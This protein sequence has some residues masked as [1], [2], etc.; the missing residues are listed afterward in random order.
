VK[1]RNIIA[2]TLLVPAA[3]LVNS[4]SSSS[5]G[6]SVAGGPELE[7]QAN[8]ICGVNQVCCSCDVSG[9]CTDCVTSDNNN[10]GSCGHVCTGGSY[11]CNKQCVTD[12]GTHCGCPQVSCPS[13]VCAA[14]LCNCDDAA[15]PTNYCCGP[16]LLCLDTACPGCSAN[17]DCEVFNPN[18]VCCTAHGYCAANSSQ[19]SFSN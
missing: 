15:C 12:T 11:C 1:L 6:D 19:C 16:E 2:A 10:C 3:G 14:G 8:C 18:Y 13:G 9:H 7:P 5:V 4:C 17:S